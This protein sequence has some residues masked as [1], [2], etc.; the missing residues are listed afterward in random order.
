MRLFYRL[1]HLHNTNLYIQKGSQDPDSVAIYSKRRSL[2][3][4]HCFQG[5]Q[6]HSI[7]DMT[8]LGCQEQIGSRVVPSMLWPV[9][10]GLATSL[11][12]Q[13]VGG[14]ARL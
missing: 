3:S 7:A 8:L 4:Q 14:L 1:H 11:H 6:V 12:L 5:Q 10:P 2:Q 13:C 9:M